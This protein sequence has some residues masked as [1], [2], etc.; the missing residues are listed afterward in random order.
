M[1]ECAT[2]IPPPQVPPPPYLFWCGVLHEEHL[3]LKKFSENFL[4]LKKNWSSKNLAPKFFKEVISN[5]RKWFIIF[6][7][8]ILCVPKPRRHNY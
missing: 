5:S 2:G 8:M 7:K 3:D 6:Y 1:F 4:R